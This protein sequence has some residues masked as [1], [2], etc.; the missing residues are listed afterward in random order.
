MSCSVMSR[1]SFCSLAMRGERLDALVFLL[2]AHAGGRLIE[3]QRLFPM[4][5]LGHT[6]HV[7]ALVTVRHSEPQRV[8]Q[9]YGRDDAT[10]APNPTMNMQKAG[11]P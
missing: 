5:V 11:N 1:V 8:P 4:L 3:K 10:V 2:R 7:E 6:P 9:Q